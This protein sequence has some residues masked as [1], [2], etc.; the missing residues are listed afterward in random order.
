MIRAAASLRPEILRVLAVL[1]VGVVE[2]EEESNKS[3]STLEKSL[4]SLSSTVFGSW[5]IAMVK[6]HAVKLEGRDWIKVV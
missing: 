6:T 2:E 3:Y 5:S 4:L 1:V